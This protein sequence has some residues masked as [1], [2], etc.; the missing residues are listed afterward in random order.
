ML[1]GY[2]TNSG[3]DAYMIFNPD[4]N[5]IHN[6]SDIIWLKTM[7]YQEKLTTEMVL[8]MTQFDDSDINKIEVGWK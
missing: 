4:T 1:V 2:N 7:F 5:I 8:N 6:I 3:D